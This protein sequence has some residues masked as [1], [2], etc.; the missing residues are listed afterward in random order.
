[1]TILGVLVSPL[2]LPHQSFSYCLC[3]QMSNIITHVTDQ[4]PWLGRKTLMVA[5]ISILAPHIV[6]LNSHT[7][8]FEARFIYL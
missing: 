5:P 4:Q 7:M 3:L 8:A 6:F 1:M 2:P